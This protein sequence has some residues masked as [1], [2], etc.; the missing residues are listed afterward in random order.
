MASRNMEKLTES[1]KIPDRYGMTVKEVSRIYDM[2][3]EGKIYD[4]ITMAFEFGFV[5]GSRAERKKRSWQR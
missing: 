4:A 3:T 1:A 5:M 2:I